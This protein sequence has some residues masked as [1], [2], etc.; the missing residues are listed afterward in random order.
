MKHQTRWESW[1]IAFKAYYDD[2]IAKRVDLGYNGYPKEV[3][4]ESELITTKASESLNALFKRSTVMRNFNMSWNNVL[5]RELHKHTLSLSDKIVSVCMSVY[6]R[7]HVCVCKVSIHVLVFVYYCSK[8]V[9]IVL[10]L[11]RTVDKM[12]VIWYKLQVY[13]ADI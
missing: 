4:V 8:V 10:G 13:T 6:A 12:L 9:N 5:L 11:E 7:A 1:S 2:R 3:G